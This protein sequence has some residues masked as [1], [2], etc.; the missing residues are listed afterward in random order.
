MQAASEI[1]IMMKYHN[2]ICLQQVNALKNSI[3]SDNIRFVDKIASDISESCVC[4]SIRSL[5]CIIKKHSRTTE[6]AT[7]N[8]HRRRLQMCDSDGM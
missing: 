7:T 4:C 1:G 8:T 5:P 2:A 6:A 3:I